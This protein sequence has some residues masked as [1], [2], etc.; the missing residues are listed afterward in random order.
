LDERE[1]VGRKLVIAGCYTPALLDL[2]EEPLD[3]I[4]SAVKMWT[5]ADRL[6]SPEGQKAIADYKIGGEQFFDPNA[7][8]PNA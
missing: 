3:Q 6:F 5:E 1:V 2:V 4:S 8:D 7:D